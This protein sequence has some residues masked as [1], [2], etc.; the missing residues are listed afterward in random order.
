MTAP[1]MR[2][3]RRCDQAGVN[4]V[5]DVEGFSSQTPITIRAKSGARDEVRDGVIGHAGVV[6]RAVILSFSSV[7]VLRT[8]AVI[9][10]QSSI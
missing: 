5:R 3:Q 9:S 1:N 2:G 7:Q 4:K 10:E 8:S 6:A